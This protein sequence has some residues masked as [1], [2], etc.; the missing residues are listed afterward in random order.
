MA[1]ENRELKF[2]GMDASL[3]TSL[4]E[5]GFVCTN[6]AKDCDNE[7]EYFV[8]Y[9]MND[10]LFGTGYIEDSDLNNSL[11][12]LNGNP[13]TFSSCYNDKQDFYND[14]FVNKLNNLMHY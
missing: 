14:S 8:I 11:R 4:I 6:E 9:R 12:E 13:K 3:E 5:Y 2:L 1:K 7:N 10:G